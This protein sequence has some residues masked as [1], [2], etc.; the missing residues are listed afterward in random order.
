VRTKLAVLIFSLSLI[1]ATPVRS[2]ASPDF[3]GDDKAKWNVVLHQQQQSLADPEPAKAQVVF[4]EDADMRQSCLLCT[5]TTRVAVDGEWAG[6]N[7]GNSYLILSIAPGEHHLCTSWQS[8]RRFLKH[9]KGQASF[10]AEQGETYFYRIRITRMGYDL[11]L[12]P[13]DKDEGAFRLKSAT[14]STATPQLSAQ[15]RELLSKNP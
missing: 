4:I 3:C 11:Q 7:Q 15:S 5:V 13:V 2:L 9:K 8:T 10:T 12:V 14:F 1:L 6:A